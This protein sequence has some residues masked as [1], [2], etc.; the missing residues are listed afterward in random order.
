[1]LYAVNLNALHCMEIIITM[2]YLE[3]DWYMM[4]Q[5]DAIR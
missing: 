1:M 5:T 3:L 4:R 2:L